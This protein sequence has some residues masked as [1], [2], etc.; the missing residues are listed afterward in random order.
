MTHRKIKVVKRDA[1]V[2]KAPVEQKQPED[3]ERGMSN[4]VKDWIT[5]RRRNSQR[6]TARDKRKFARLSKLNNPSR[7]PA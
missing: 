6:E 2:P 7:K 5:E 4:T 3:T 1:A